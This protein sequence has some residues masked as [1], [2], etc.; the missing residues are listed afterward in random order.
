M[1]VVFFIRKIVSYKSVT[2]EWVEILKTKTLWYILVKK[3]YRYRINIIYL[4]VFYKKSLLRLHDGNSWNIHLE[5][6]LLCWRCS[7]LCGEK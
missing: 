3:D 4:N 7:N 6:K 1:N 5:D 2:E